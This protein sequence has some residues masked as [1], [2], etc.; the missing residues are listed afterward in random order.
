MITKFGTFGADAQLMS[1]F[2]RSSDAR[3]AGR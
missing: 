2:Q 3:A 1:Q